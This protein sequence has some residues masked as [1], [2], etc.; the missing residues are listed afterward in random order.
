MLQIE[1][2]SSK[3]T[4]EAFLEDKQ[5][6]FYPFFQSWQWGQMQ[7]LLGFT[8][9]RIG[10]YKDK[11]LVAICQII[12]VPAK[13]GHYL[14]LRHGPVL[15][16]FEK[17]VFKALIEYTKQ[18]AI[19]EKALFIRISPLV[20]KE[21]VDFLMLK[22]MGF[23][24]API[25]NMDA[26]VCWVLDITK[27]EDQLLGE[28]RKTHR[29]L[30]RKAS[31]M[32]IKI[33]RTKNVN[34]ISAFIPLYKNLSDRKHFVPHKGVK[35][36]FEVFAKDNKSMLFLAQYEKKIIAGALFSFIGNTA[37]YRHSASN[38]RYS[39][40]PA[41]YAL[42]WEAIREAKK[43][44]KEL[45][46]FWGIAPVGSSNRH[47][48]RGLSLFK[49]G[50]GGRMEEFMHALDMPLGIWYWRTYAIE[51]FTKIIKGY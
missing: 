3:K 27:P 43:Q 36:E 38:E 34:D 50:F 40:I 28:M 51:L 49:T 1:E 46:N 23:R 2:I 9:W 33:V 22:N 7:Q 37:I 11:T 26:E 6:T 5:I 4:W 29:Y 21:F 19:K 35:E 18:L 30:I 13:R 14:H 8:L 48:W 15:I 47:P 25:H 45:F 16:P 32:N 31:N 41:M 42:L 10:V 39:E 17:S 12:S 44:K 20:K 24:D